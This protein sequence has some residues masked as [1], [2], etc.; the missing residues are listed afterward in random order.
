MLKFSRKNVLNNEYAQRLRPASYAW[1]QRH[2][3]IDNNCSILNLILRSH[4]AVLYCMFLSYLFA[5]LSEA[6]T[7]H[8]SSFSLKQQNY[9]I[10]LQKSVEVNSFIFFFKVIPLALEEGTCVGGCPLRKVKGTAGVQNHPD[11]GFI[12]FSP[13]L[14]RHMKSGELICRGGGDALPQ[15]PDT[16]LCSGCFL[17]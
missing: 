2:C 17:L 9:R 6:R 15:T 11:S 5:S 14:R 7:C 16:Q 12:F 13:G 8:H 3:L 1:I 4:F 10:C